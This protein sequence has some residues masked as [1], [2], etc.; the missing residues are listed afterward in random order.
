MSDEVDAEVLQVFGGQLRQDRR[1][2][3]VVAK[4]RLVLLE[5]EV[6]EPC[7]N[8]HARLPDAV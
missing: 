6:V 4:R 8:V 2:N 7:R 3:G 5:P 1:V